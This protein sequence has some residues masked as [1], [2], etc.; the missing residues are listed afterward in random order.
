MLELTCVDPSRGP[1]EVVEAMVDLAGVRRDYAG[2]EVGLEIAARSTVASLLQRRAVDRAFDHV[3]APVLILHG[4]KDRLVSVEAARRAVQRRPT[5]HL[6][7]H[8]D[9]GHVVQL[10]APEWTVEQIRQWWASWE[11]PV[12]A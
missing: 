5:W 8:P 9:L 4:E 7:T 12:V 11:A 2:T 1:H 6:V 3:R 10:E